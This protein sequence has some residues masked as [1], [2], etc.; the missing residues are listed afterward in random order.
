MRGG[1]RGERRRGE[2]RVLKTIFRTFDFLN[3]KNSLAHATK[4][5]HSHMNEL[6]IIPP[7]YHY[8]FCLPHH[9]KMADL[10]HDGYPF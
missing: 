9:K 6:P 5:S 2:R 3:S 4:S 1:E 10:A 8:M 7:M